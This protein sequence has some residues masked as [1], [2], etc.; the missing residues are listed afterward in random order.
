MFQIDPVRLIDL[1]LLL[2]FG[3][4]GGS[5]SKWDPGPHA[6]FF[7]WVGRAGRGWAIQGVTVVVVGSQK[8]WKNKKILVFDGVGH[9]F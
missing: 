4:G 3:G 5:L 1:V 9:G 6:V 8:Y 7:S 2:S